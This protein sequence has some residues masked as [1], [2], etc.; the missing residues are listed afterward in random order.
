MAITAIT[1]NDALTVKL[2]EKQMFNVMENESYFMTRFA[3]ESENN[4]VQVK[5]DLTKTKGDAITFGIVY[6]LT[7]LGVDETQTLE[8]NEESLTHYDYAL[9]L[10]EYAHAVK[11]NKMSQKRVVF[12]I[13]STAVAKLQRWGRDK[14]DTELFTTIDA[15]S[16]KIFYG[17]DADS[18]ASLEAADK[19]TPALVSKVATWA[20]TGGNDAQPVIQ[21]VNIEGGSYYAMVVHPDVLY[22]WKQNSVWVTAAGTALDRAPD[23]PFF[24]RATFFWDNVVIHEHRRVNILTTGGAGSDIPYAKTLFM[25]Q[26]AGLWAWGERPKMV[27]QT[28][29]YERERGWS[30]QMVARPGKPVFNSLDYGS[31]SVVVSR[32]QVS[33]A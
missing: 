30:W 31:V 21:E 7:G 19:L 4:I 10:K 13:P 8:G 18:I 2:W 16:T 12:D 28:K 26:Q 33:D 9:T 25:G 32:T 3:G 5:T 20:R 24:K 1:T 23:H 27:Q 15:S 14:I 17:G 6:D 11:T 22:D 29:D